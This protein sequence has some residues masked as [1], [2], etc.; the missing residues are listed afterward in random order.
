MYFIPIDLSSMQSIRDGVK[1]FLE[2]ELPL[3][4]LVNNAGVM[5][6]D[7]L[8]SVD[9]LEMTMAANVSN[10]NLYFAQ[11]VLTM[12]AFIHYH[13]FVFLHLLPYIAPGALSVHKLVTTK[14]TPNCNQRK[15][16]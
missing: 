11:V 2:M 16:S 7:R 5:M 4:V 1:I 12:V 13:A 15:T 9:G 6:N 10:K 8:E 14:I 3:H